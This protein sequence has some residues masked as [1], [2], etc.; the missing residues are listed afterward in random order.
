MPARDIECVEFRYFGFIGDPNVV[1][2][3][4]LYDIEVWWFQDKNNILE[5]ILQDLY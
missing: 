1:T 2:V 3:R 5:V 4:I